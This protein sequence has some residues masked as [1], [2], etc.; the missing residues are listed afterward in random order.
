MFKW[1]KISYCNVILGLGVCAMWFALGAGGYLLVTDY[2]ELHQRVD[3]LERILRKPVTIK[4]PIPDIKRPTL[5]SDI[6]HT[7]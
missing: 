5:F 1:I 3:R 4:I 2:I 7:T 6:E